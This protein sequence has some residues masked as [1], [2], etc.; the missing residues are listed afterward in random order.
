MF[1]SFTRDSQL[2]DF[3]FKSLVVNLAEYSLVCTDCDMVAYA[4]FHE[5]WMMDVVEFSASIGRFLLGPG[6]GRMIGF[7]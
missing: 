1:I 4:N 3:C 6:A 5:Y 7:A 2:S